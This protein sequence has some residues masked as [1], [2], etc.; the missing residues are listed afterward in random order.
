MKLLEEIDEKKVQLIFITHQQKLLDVIDRT[1][2]ALLNPVVDP[3]DN[4]RRTFKI[5]R[6][7]NVINSYAEDILRKYGLSR[8]QLMMRLEDMKERK[9]EKENENEDK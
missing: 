5:R 4:N 8:D 7:G 9:E 1:K 6:V 3:L 2:I